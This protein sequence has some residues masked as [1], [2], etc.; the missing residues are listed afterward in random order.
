MVQPTWIDKAY[1]RKSVVPYLVIRRFLNKWPELDLKHI[2]KC[3]YQHLINFEFQ[4]AICFFPRTDTVNHFKLLLYK[5]LFGILTDAEYQVPN[6]F[7]GHNV[8][9]M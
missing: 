2:L 1:S 4:N 6:Y 7:F 9:A 5:S 8:G 3:H